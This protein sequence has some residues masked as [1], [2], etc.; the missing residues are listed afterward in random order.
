M[1]SNNPSNPDITS[2]LPTEG[3]ANASNSKFLPFMTVSLL[4]LGLATTSYLYFKKQQQIQ[5]TANLAGQEK[6]VVSTNQFS[7]QQT[8]QNQGQSSQWSI[9]NFLS[10]LTQGNQAAKDQKS[11]SQNPFNNS[12]EDRF[13]V[14]Y[15][16]GSHI[17]TEYAKYLIEK[18]FGVILVDYQLH[19]LTQCEQQLR[20]TYQDYMSSKVIQGKNDETKDYFATKVKTIHIDQNRKRIDEECLNKQLDGLKNFSVDCF[21]NCTNTLQYKHPQFNQ[22]TQQFE[23]GRSHL[24]ELVQQ[25][26]LRQLFDKNLS[27]LE[28][29]VQYMHRRFFIPPLYTSII[30]IKRKAKKYSPSSKNRPQIQQMSQLEK[31]IIIE[32][33]GT[34]K[35]NSPQ[36][37]QE[38]LQNTQVLPQ[39]NL[40]LNLAEDENYS[41]QDI[42]DEL[43]L[44]S[45]EVC[46][47]FYQASEEFN[48]YFGYMLGKQQYKRKVRAI[49]IEIDYQRLQQLIGGE[50]NEQQ[51]QVKD[52]DYGRRKVLQSFKI[53]NYVM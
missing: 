36:Q 38:Q 32:E 50:R 27:L 15:G 19:R 47:I 11:L 26:L 53:L 1:K 29:F 28:Q 31:S 42:N 8:S 21:I 39:Y 40:L 44:S 34:S 5:N 33:N 20:D 13:I 23:G 7:M 2:N 14:I 16:A 35:P 49:S 43:T 3:Q 22:A 45:E 24:Q 30:N 52:K 51:L 18:G 10:K 41:A 6:T 17:G 48:T 37:T 25:E 12:K 46:R 4:G 9:F